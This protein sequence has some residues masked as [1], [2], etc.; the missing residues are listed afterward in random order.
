M[1]ATATITLQAAVIDLT[2]NDINVRQKYIM[3]Q[4]PTAVVHAFR[5]VATADVPELLELG[6][7]SVSLCDGILFIPNG[8][9]F[10][11]DTT[12]S[13][14]GVASDYVER[15]RATDSEAIYFTPPQ[16]TA[17]IAVFCSTAAPY[18]YVVIGRTP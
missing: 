7:V 15:V 6:D 11:L 13:V 2:A 17:S 16:G 18:E 10:G 1:A 14:G 3:A 8:N 5:T 9:D 4:T 12:V